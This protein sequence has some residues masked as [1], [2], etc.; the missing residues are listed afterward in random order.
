MK[1]QTNEYINKY[2]NERYQ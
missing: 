2:K 1:H